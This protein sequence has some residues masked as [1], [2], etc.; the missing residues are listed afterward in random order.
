MKK[1]DKLIVTNR[2]ALR[3]KYGNGG[4]SVDAAMNRL[5]PADKKRGLSSKRV[6]L[7]ALES[8]LKNPD[9]ARPTLQESTKIA[10]DKACRR[11]VPDY[12][13]IVGATD[14]V[15]RKG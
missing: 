13:L 6:Y 12:V 10:V 8:G 3:R 4:R 11:C 5:I 14:I 9:I 1:L 15:R 7:D 2:A